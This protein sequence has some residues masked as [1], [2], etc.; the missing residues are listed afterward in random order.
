MVGELLPTY[1]ENLLDG[2]SRKYD[3]ALRPPGGKAKATDLA[4]KILERLTEGSDGGVLEAG[5]KNLPQ[6]ING[7]FPRQ[8]KGAFKKGC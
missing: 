5:D 1:V 6:E 2:N 4:G 7:M 8:S 3:I